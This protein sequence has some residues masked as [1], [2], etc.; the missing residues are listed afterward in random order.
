MYFALHDNLF[1]WRLTGRAERVRVLV[2]WLSLCLRTR[3]RGD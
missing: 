3:L 1:G 2:A